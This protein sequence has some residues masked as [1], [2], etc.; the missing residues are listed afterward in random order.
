MS[1]I[2]DDFDEDIRKLVMLGKQTD[3][4]SVSGTL[5]ADLD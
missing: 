5:Q 2:G 1:R 3:A 4:T